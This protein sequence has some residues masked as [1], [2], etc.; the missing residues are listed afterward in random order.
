[1]RST[2]PSLPDPAQIVPSLD[3]MTL[4]RNG[5]TVSASTDA[6]GPRNTRPSASIDRSSTSPFRKSFWVDTVQ[7]VGAAPDRAAHP[8][9]ASNKAQ[10]Q[11]RRDNP[12][13]VG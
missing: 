4:H 6:D 11:R 9:E 13:L 1:M 5:A 10:A 8:E 7:N 2:L 3:A 12:E